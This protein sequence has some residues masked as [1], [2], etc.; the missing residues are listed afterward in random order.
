[1]PEVACWA[2]WGACSTCSEQGKFC[3]A[4]EYLEQLQEQ[5]D[6]GVDWVLT[7]TLEMIKK[8]LLDTRSDPRDLEEILSWMRGWGE[9]FYIHT[10]HA[11]SDGPSS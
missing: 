4:A 8:I 1:M 6:D 3:Q 7:A 5:I 10:L 9:P 2:A 11:P